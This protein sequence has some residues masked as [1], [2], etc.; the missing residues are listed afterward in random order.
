MR[1]KCKKCNTEIQINKYTLVFRN[2]ELQNKDAFCC[3]EEMECL[4]K[5]EGMPT[6]IR[7]EYTKEDR[8]IQHKAKQ[9]AARIKKDG[10]DKNYPNDKP[11][12]RR[13]N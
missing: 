13:I 9:K 1:Y 11:P 4:T 5:N 3:N 2:M 7:N 12:K 10:Y 6:I 8:I